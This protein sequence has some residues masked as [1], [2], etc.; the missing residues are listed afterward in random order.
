MY[1]E[2]LARRTLRNGGIGAVV[3]VIL[4]FVPLVLLIAPLVGGAVA[5]FLERNG[6]KRGALAGGI[7]G[8]LMAALSAVIVAVI[9]AIRFGDLPFLFA[10]APIRSLGIATALSVAASLGQILVAA[11][12]GGLGGLL[13]ADRR[14][15]IAREPA[16]ESHS[17]DGDR[18][19]SVA[20]IIG[21]LVVGLVTF[22][23]VALAVTVALDPFIWPSALVGLPA[24]FVAGAAVAVVGYHYLAHRNDP[25]SRV[26][27]RAISVG[28]V[29]IAV[30]FAMVVGG[31]FLLGEQRMTETT[32][33]TYQYDVTIAT[34]DTL[35]NAT[36]YVP[37]P[38]DG[39]TGTSELGEYFVENVRYE[40]HT[41]AVEGYEQPA[42]P[43]EFS[44]ELVETDNGPML[45][46]S[47]DRIEV[48]RVYYR[49]ME[50]ETMGWYEQ[51]DQEEYDP[52]DPSMGVQ[53]D[54]S[55]RF[56]VRLAANDTIDTADPFGSEPLLT[57]KSDLQETD[58]RY[59]SETARCYEYDSL[60]YAS[61]ETDAET[62]VY[63]SAQLDGRNEWFSG[64]W[65]GNEYREWS[66]IELRGPQSGWVLTEGELEIGS[67]NYRD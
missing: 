46:I 53:D 61:Y 42:D 17:A 31:L 63:V 49:T 25:D 52:N 12:G 64:G 16:E 44:Y 29:G 55:F 9:V 23:V 20:R 36:V 33:S 24:G 47:T 39:E 60:V 7:A 8:A 35:E 3:G 18:V 15:V 28:A 62:T 22:A 38:V 27:W 5:G 6:P 54:G 67:G 2:T 4:G 58:C 21:S 10:D 14:R 34:D 32:E 50:N 45:A 37:L 1:M 48:S 59:P 13:E 11:I 57:P 41:P 40:R 65:S 26:N 66:R 43:V 30:V 51:V 19:L 56:S